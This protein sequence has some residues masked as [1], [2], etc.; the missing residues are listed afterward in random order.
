[1]PAR[2][3]FA[4]AV[5][6]EVT[7]SGT[8]LTL[9][10]G[11]RVLVDFGSYQ[12]PD[13]K[14][15][16]KDFSQIS[17]DNLSAIIVTHAHADHIGRLPLLDQMLKSNVP[18]YMTKATA[19]ITEL[20]LKDAAKLFRHLY[21][22][23]S[24]GKILK[25]IKTKEYDE[26][27]QIGNSGA[28]ATLRDAGHILGSASAEIKDTD[29]KRYVFSGDLGN[30]SPSRILKPPEL[31]KKADY[32]FLE[33]TYG[34]RLHPVE[35]PKEIF[36]EAVDFIRS[37]NGTLLIPAFSIDRTPVALHMLKTMR[38]QGL[39]RD[40]YG[41]E[42]PVHLD[43]PMASKATKIYREFPWLLSEEIQEEKQPFSFDGMYETPKKSRRNKEKGPKITEN[44]P[45]IIVSASG[46]I[47]G[48]R[49]IEHAI[50]Y[51]PSDK[52][53]L[54]LIGFAAQGT[55]AGA[56]MRGEETILIPRSI[57]GKFS[58]VPV[59]VRARVFRTQALSA[60]ADQNQLIDWLSQ[61]QD[62]KGV[63]LNHGNQPARQALSQRITEDLPGKKL[64]LPN[65]GTI[66][67]FSQKEQAL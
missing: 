22:P 10:G 64:W 40:K 44:G 21:P 67:D 7:G 15:R 5:G 31:I 50:N 9:T 63:I 41:N 48:G 53:A 61:I 32:V 20:A 59:K 8:F 54:L 30:N 42:I 3:E 19:K 25:R 26:V 1:M 38:E 34:D 16:N 55:P 4:G 11:S 14:R 24:V 65:H 23:E 49:I 27:F 36:K 60:H 56:I 29:G 2:A 18:I 52:N 47:S 13:Q 35:D 12:G 6:G 33:S 37:T 39:L 57:D 58:L 45:R 46:M 43:S 28:V 62:V 17:T 66:I 51:L